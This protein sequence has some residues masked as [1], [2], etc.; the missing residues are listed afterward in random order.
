M[1]TVFAQVVSLFEMFFRFLFPTLQ[2]IK[3][4]ATFHLDRCTFVLCD[5][6]KR[7]VDRASYEE[8]VAS[9]MNEF[10]LYRY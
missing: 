6:A 2:Y 8:S 3:T 4:K 5:K 1:V 7:W 9:L 10:V